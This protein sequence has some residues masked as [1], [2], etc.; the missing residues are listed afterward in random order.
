MLQPQNPGTDRPLFH[1]QTS[2]GSRR[3]YVLGAN[4]VRVPMREIAVASGEPGRPPEKFRVYDT[5]GPYADPDARIELQQGLPPLRLPWILGRGEYDVRDPERCVVDGNSDPDV[6]LPKRRQILRSRGNATQMH[7]ARRGLVTP[8]MEFVALREDLDAESVRDEIAR[9][10]AILPANINHPESEPMAIG[11]NFLVK[12]NANI[13]NSVVS[14]SIEEEVEKMTWAIRWGS[15][16]VMDL[17]TGRN[18]HETREW[19]IRNSPVPVGTVPIYQALEK[20]G[21]KPEE[22]T[23]DLFRETLIE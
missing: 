8:E 6:P 23:W 9:G 16:T 21:G 10:R 5:C 18:I 2:P 15:D 7:Y 22:L 19:I 13:G 1:A 4:G 12:I 20:V 11:R 3:I 14:S 17:S